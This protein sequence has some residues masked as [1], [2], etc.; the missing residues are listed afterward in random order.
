MH[1]SRILH[2]WLLGIFL[3]TAIKM[4]HGNL[5]P[6]KIWELIKI[7]GRKFAAAIFGMRAVLVN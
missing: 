2:V 5:T 7:I 6:F 1:T 3:R 4:A